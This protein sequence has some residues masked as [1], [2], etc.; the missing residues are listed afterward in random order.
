MKNVS[1]VTI[2]ILVGGCLGF[3]GLP[4]WVLPLIAATA[5]F[6]FPLTGGKSYATGF[7]AGTLLWTAVAIIQNAGNAGLLSGRIGQLFMGLQPYQLLMLT[8]L[9]GGLLGGFG[10]LTG[11]YFRL[12]VFPPKPQRYTGYR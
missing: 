2:I 9:M 8:G 7:A 6:F 4:W 3:L 5:T 10:A 11:T 12:V 1:I